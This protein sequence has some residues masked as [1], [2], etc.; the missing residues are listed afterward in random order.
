MCVEIVLDDTEVTWDL[1]VR[2]S[3][4]RMSL[5]PPTPS[6]EHRV[7]VGGCARVRDY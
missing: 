2:L 7:R 5:S 6:T 3:E 4:W 1:P